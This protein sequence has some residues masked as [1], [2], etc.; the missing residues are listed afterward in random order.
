MV[1]IDPYKH[2]EQYENWKKKTREGIPGLSTQNSDILLR[3]VSDMEMGLNVASNSQKGP[4]GFVRLN[5]IRSRIAWIMR[6]IT[7]VY[8]IDDITRVTEETLHELFLDFQQQ[9]CLKIHES[10]LYL[11]T[12]LLFLS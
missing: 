3:Y 1:K 5:N 4:R 11:Q 7:E 6:K 12:F 10:Q 9:D 2:K 8:K